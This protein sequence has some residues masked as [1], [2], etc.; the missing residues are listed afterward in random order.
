MI[1]Y[2]M[3]TAAYIIHNSLLSTMMRLPQM[4]FDTHPVGRILNR[5]SKDTDTLDNELPQIILDA[6]WCFLEV[7]YFVQYC[8]F[9]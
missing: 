3:V 1:M 2:C 6:V 5:F 8:I 9:F 7:S 4:F